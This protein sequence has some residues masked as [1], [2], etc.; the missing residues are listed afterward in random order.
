MDKF[1]RRENLALFTKRLADPSLTD[2]QRKVILALLSEGQLEG[3]PKHSFDA[4]QSTGG[5]MS[6]LTS[7]S[8]V[9]DQ[10]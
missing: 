1:I 2:S 10:C 8:Q 5:T 6:I 7:R 4:G 3:R 9:G